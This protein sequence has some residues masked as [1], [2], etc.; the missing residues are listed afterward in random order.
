MRGEHTN[1]YTGEGRQ[2]K[3]THALDYR[4]L[5]AAGTYTGYC[6]REARMFDAYCHQ[7]RV[8]EGKDIRYA[9]YTQGD[10]DCKHW[11][12]GDDIPTEEAA[13]CLAQDCMFDYCI[14]RRDVQLDVCEDFVIEW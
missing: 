5:E 11:E 14:H 9:D 7:Y 4:A 6:L 13:H 10:R 2:K 3:G 1:R 12:N 8:R